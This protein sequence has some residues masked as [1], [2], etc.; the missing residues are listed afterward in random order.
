MQNLLFVFV[1]ANQGQLIMSTQAESLRESL[2]ELE[3]LLVKYSP[4]MS[5]ST[6]RIMDTAIK[7]GDVFAEVSSTMWKPAGR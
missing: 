1:I 7:Y 4:L 2:H 5:E 6:E 3:G